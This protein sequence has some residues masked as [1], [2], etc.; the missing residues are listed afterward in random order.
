V[1]VFLVLLGALY[2][3]GYL[4][5][6]HQAQEAS[7]DAAGR[8]TAV[9]SVNVA[10]PNETISNKDVLLPCDI[11]PNQQTSLYART[12]GYL[13]KVYVDISD[14]V[15]AGQLLAEIDTPEV[16]AQ[17]VQS[18]ASLEQAKANLVKAKSDLDLA[19]KTLE[20][21]KHLPSGAASQQDVDQRQAA[22]EVA[23]AAVAQTRASIAVAEADVQRLTVLQGFEKI[24]APF[25][26]IITARN[27]DVGALL[28]ASGT[29]KSLFDLV[30][31]DT[32]R[33]DVN[34]PQVYASEINPGEPAFLAVRNYP[35]RQFKGTV[36]RASSVLNSNT[37]TMLFELTFA[38]PDGLLYSGMY[39]QVRLNLSK[40]NPVLV[41]PT[42]AMLFN[43]NGTQVALVQEG[44]K[45]HYQNIAVGRDLGTEMEILSGLP[46]DAL[47]IANPTA[48]MT[49]GTSVQPVMPQ[50]TAQGSPRPTTQPMA[51]DGQGDKAKMD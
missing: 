28:S 43:A 15:H 22:Y 4:P 36:A 30:Q 25:S 27:Y 26:G 17:L 13:K 46:K 21:Y 6:Q 20:R 23:V 1:V 31:S 51:R 18:R 37:R 8:T 49:E 35:G 3:I 38:N 11:R 14:R 29:G 7:A 33:V 32:L 19:Q 42:S 41:I 2:I 16:D 5:Y 45:V 34:V 24:T 40:R 10:R 50:R 12:N 39:G 44:N 48:Q 47:V 9:P